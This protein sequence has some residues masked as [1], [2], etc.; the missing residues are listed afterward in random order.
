MLLAGSV[1]SAFVDTESMGDL[2][3]KAAV[4]PTAGTANAYAY[5]LAGEYAGGVLNV[6]YSLNAAAT[7]VNVV[8]KN[9]AGEVVYTQKLGAQA[10]G[11]HTAAV[12]LQ[13]VDSGDYSWAFSVATAK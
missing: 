7:D 3:F 10:A 8:V 1:A 6:S 2:S 9:S 11:T 12:N 13:N 4:T 5:G